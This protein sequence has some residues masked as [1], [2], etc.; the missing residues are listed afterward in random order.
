M[1]N[2]T[3]CGGLIME[4]GVAYAYAGKVCHCALPKPAKHGDIIPVGPDEF[5]KVRQAALQQPRMGGG[6]GLAPD[7]LKVIPA[8]TLTPAEFVQWLRGYFAGSGALP[9]PIADMLEKVR[10]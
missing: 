1:S 5:E 10:K 2:C 7:A 8:D 3:S 6:I 4:Q 9:A